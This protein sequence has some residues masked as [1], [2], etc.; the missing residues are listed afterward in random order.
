M[1]EANLANYTKDLEKGIA[2]KTEE[3]NARI[4]ELTKLNKIMVGRELKMIELKK[5]IVDLKNENKS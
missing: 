5:E 1:I 4:N 2:D 3:L